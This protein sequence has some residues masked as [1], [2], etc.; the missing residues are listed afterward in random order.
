MT[1]SGFT[2]TDAMVD[3]A[4]EAGRQR[5]ARE[6][7]ATD[8]R[9]DAERDALEIDLRQG[10]GLRV[11]RGAIAELAAVPAEALAGLDLSPAGTGLDLDDHDV[12][13]SVHGLVLSLLSPSTLAAGLGQRGGAQSTPAKRD[14]AR[15]NGRLGGRPKKPP[16]AA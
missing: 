1:E 7:S 13:I 15:R 3:A 11:P 9:Y 10:F 4:L 5:Q 16:Q 8:V 6:F 14:S 2:I 12:H